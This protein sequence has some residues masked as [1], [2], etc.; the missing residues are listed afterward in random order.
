MKKPSQEIL[1]TQKNNSSKAIKAPYP[2]NYPS[3]E[4]MRR[5]PS[6]KNFTSE[7]KFKPKIKLN[8]GLDYFNDYAQKKFIRS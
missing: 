7:F 3:D 2:K 4:P 1:K 8:K 5:C 6:I